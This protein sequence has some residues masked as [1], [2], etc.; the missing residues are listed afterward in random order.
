MQVKSEHR[1]GSSSPKAGMEEIRLNITERNEAA[2]LN[3]MGFISFLSGAAPCKELV[4]SPRG[5]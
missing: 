5:H 1:E 2:S 3:E 4:S